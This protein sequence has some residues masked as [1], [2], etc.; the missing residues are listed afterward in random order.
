MDFST[1]Q[2]ALIVC[3]SF[4]TCIHVI[5]L[6]RILCLDVRQLCCLG[7]RWS[8]L[9]SRLWTLACCKQQKDVISQRVASRMEHRQQQQMSTCC[10]MLAHVAAVC[11]ISIVFNTCVGGTR[12][13]TQEQ[14]LLAMVSALALIVA[15]NSP[16]K[17]RQTAV[18]CAFRVL[19]VCVTLWVFLGSSTSDDLIM[20]AM[21]A[22][23]LRLPLS[24]ANM[25]S[26]LTLFWNIICGSANCL[27]LL[28]SG[29]VGTSAMF[30]RN[31]VFFE[32]VMAIVIP[33]TAAGFLHVTREHVRHE[34]EAA[35]RK[36]EQS[37]VMKLFDMVCDVVLCLDSSFRMADHSPNFAAMLMLESS[38]SL[39]GM[40]FASFISNPEDQVRFENN[41]VS[42]T[43]DNDEF[44]ACALNVNIRGSNAMGFIVEIL[45]VPFQGLDNSTHYMVGVLEVTDSNLAPLK[46]SIGKQPGKSSKSP[47]KMPTHGTPPFLDSHPFSPQPKLTANL[48]GEAASDGADTS[49]APTEICAEDAD[50]EPSACSQSSVGMR[51]PLPHLLPTSLKAQRITM[52]DLIASWNVPLPRQSC[53]SFHATQVVIKSLLRSLRVAPC[54]KDLHN[55]EPSSCPSCGVLDRMDDDNCCT[56]CGNGPSS[57]YMSL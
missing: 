17:A 32:A 20:S 15:S 23:I 42:C 40:E 29:P 12:W 36:I 13:M 21:S 53:C 55:G 41:L 57:L 33:S 45:A 16:E 14:D 47:M 46:N 4:L 27:K 5:S 18:H 37:A 24:I 52:V 9:K 26:R 1:K 49:E 44:T 43:H 31:L 11:M 8:T 10:G 25:D 19:M 56:I 51:P 30:E 3:G 2:W 28:T 22:W 7:V 50:G 6:L 54:V 38:R 39:Q 34:V 48:D 35:A